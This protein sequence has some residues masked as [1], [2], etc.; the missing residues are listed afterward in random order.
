MLNYFDIKKR[1]K[2]EV[3]NKYLALSYY[4]KKQYDDVSIM[5]NALQLELFKSTIDESIMSSNAAKL[6]SVSDYNAH[7]TINNTYNIGGGGGGAAAS[8]AFSQIA[9]SA[10]WSITHNLGYKPSEPTIV[11]FTGQNLEGIINNIDN[12]HTTIT[13]SSPKSGY[14]YFS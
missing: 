11:S 14:A 8:Y 5:E 6:L 3:Y 10:V 2:K 9:L 1:F 13:F 4:V 12:N 7:I